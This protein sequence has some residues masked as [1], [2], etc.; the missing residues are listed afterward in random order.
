MDERKRFVK[1]STGWGKVMSNKLIS[2]ADE[3]GSL[4]VM[5][6]IENASS[7]SDQQAL[8]LSDLFV[9]SPQ[10]S[11]T[12]DKHDIPLRSAAIGAKQRLIID[13]PNSEP[14]A[15]PKVRVYPTLGVAI[16]I[17]TPN[18]LVQA[19]NDNRI[20]SIDE[21]PSVSLIAPLDWREDNLDTVSSPLNML[22]VSKLWEK[23]LTGKGTLV[24]HLDTG[25]D[26]GHPNLASCLNA[27]AEYDLNG[28]FVQDGSPRESDT[29]L[30]HGTH[31]AGIISGRNISGTHHGTAP[32]SHLNSAMVLGGGD[33]LLRM[34]AGL[35]WIANSEAKIVNGSMGLPNASQ[36]FDTIMRR[37]RALDILPIMAIGN[38]GSGTSRTPG[39]S[40]HALSVGACDLSG[41]VL[42]GS[43]SEVIPESPPRVVPTVIAPGLDIVSASTNQ[44]ERALSGSS[45]AAPH[46][47]GICALLKEAMPSATS[48]DLEDAIKLSATRSAQV[49]ETRGNLGVPDAVKA[50][51]ILTGTAFS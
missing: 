36:A 20:L 8:D 1:I 31:T 26:I 38:G 33:E 28:N 4:R 10:Q 12:L 15:H 39:N 14:S 50:H 5:V 41:V 23:G 29:S 45:Q 40:K 3:H 2:K 32:G 21:A 18:R 27:F 49:P 13:T 22:N 30:G 25:I 44:G 48:G 43:S 16:G 24:G 51:A 7:L 19:L 42:G 9:Y 46:V 6:E 11:K 17:I 35:E 34:I 47:A 37:L